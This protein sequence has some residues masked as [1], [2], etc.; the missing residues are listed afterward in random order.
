MDRPVFIGGCMRSGTTLLMQLLDCSRNIAM[1]PYE[2]YFMANFYGAQARAPKAAL[3]SPPSCLAQIGRLAHGNFSAFVESEWV[4]KEILSARS[5]ADA[6]DV[7]CREMAWR[8]GK[9][10][11]GDK[12]PGNEYFATDI[13]ALFPS[14]RFIYVL[15]DPRD[16]VASK[17]DRSDSASG[18]L[19]TRTQE[20]WRSAWLWRSSAQAHAWNATNLDPARYREVRFE[21]LVS[22][23]AAALTSLSD[24]VGEDLG[25][26]VSL[27][28]DRFLYRQLG[29]GSHS[30]RQGSSNT[31]YQETAPPPG[32]IARL[33]VGRY[34]GRLS[35]AERVIVAFLCRAISK[36]SVAGHAPTSHGSFGARERR[37]AYR[38]T[39]KAKFWFGQKEL[40]LTSPIG[41]PGNDPSLKA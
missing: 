2:S 26:I 27:A 5:Y 15:R 37:L 33:P 34:R 20:I 25:G 29:P 22:D 39:R 6:F 3:P 4:R 35:V 9:S 7:V 23:P 18:G 21:Q 32:E 38:R 14:S 13:L 36:G 11:W 16:V 10:R 1:P 31:S 30:F 28:G 8:V 40:R 19:R 17:R 41:S 24:F 12:T